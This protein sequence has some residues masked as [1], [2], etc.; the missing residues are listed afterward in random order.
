MLWSYFTPSKGT[1][2]FLNYWGQGKWNFMIILST[3]A[4]ENKL[5][6]EIEIDMKMIFCFC[7]KALGP[8]DM[9][10]GQWKRHWKWNENW[11]NENKIETKWQWNCITANTKLNFIV[12]SKY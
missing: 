7:L 11:M 9:N 2:A 8:V 1:L 6:K 12:V 5:E 3:K 4:M 10:Q